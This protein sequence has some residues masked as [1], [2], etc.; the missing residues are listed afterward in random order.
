[1]RNCGKRWVRLNEEEGNQ[2]EDDDEKEDDDEGDATDEKDEGEDEVKKEQTKIALFS[3][4]ALAH[5]VHSNS[6][7]LL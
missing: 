6:N 7:R 2:G 4:I 1:M 5:E 3:S